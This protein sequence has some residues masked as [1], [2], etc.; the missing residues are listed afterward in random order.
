MP[1]QHSNKNL[2]E[3]SFISAATIN[4]LSYYSLGQHAGIRRKFIAK[5]QVSADFA[6]SKFSNARI[7]LLGDPNEMKYEYLC[8]GLHLKQVV[9]IPTTRS[10]TTVKREL[11]LNSQNATTGSNQGRI[12]YITTFLTSSLSKTYELLLMTI[13]SIF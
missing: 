2:I 5:F 6:L 9:N 3:D 8:R 1:P 4:Q 10:L 7:L 11:P 13:S 12:Q